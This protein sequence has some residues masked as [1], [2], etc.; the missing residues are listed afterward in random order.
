MEVF[1]STFVLPAVFILFYMLSLIFGGFG[2]LLLAIISTFLSI[3]IYFLLGVNISDC[4]RFNSIP[5]G[6]CGYSDA[7]TAMNLMFW[8]CITFSIILVIR[9]IRRKK[10][11]KT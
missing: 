3:I 8:F 10:I 9:F 4:A 1:M 6:G 7:T 2:I 5:F 11:S